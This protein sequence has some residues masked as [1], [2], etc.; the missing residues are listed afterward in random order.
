MEIE[1][2][3]SSCPAPRPPSLQKVWLAVLVNQGAF[4]GLGTLMMRRRVGYAQSA[5][6]VAGFVLSMG[7]MIWYLTCLAGYIMHSNWSAE[8]FAARSQPYRWALY[9]GLGLCAISWFWA[10]LSSLSLLREAR[11]HSPLA[12]VSGGSSPDTGL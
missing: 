11:Q 7:F 12:P 3:P 10:L 6:M 5:V 4:P 1:P 9:W 2:D 8:E